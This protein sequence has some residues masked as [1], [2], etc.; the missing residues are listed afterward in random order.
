MI[1]LKRIQLNNFLSH[2]N[3]I[4]NFD[5]NEKAL[6]DGLSGAGK[7]SIFDAIIWNLYGI[8]RADN[9]SLVR[10]GAKLGEVI[11][12]LK[13]DD[14]IVS[15]TRRI[16]ISGKHHL[17][18]T[19]EQIGGIKVPFVTSGLRE[20]QN[21]I[22][23]DLIGASYL[24]FINSVAYVQGNTESFVMQPASK[25]KDLL[26]EIVKTEDY[27]K[28]YENARLTLI[29]LENE[30]NRV[31]WDINALETNLNDLNAVIETR[32]DHIKVISEKTILLN[33]IEPK[34]QVLESKKAELMAVKQGVANLD[35][36]LIEAMRDA[37][38][39][40]T[41]LSKK[42]TKITD[43]KQLQELISTAPEAKKELKESTSKLTKLRK[44][45]SENSK[46]EKERNEFLQKKPVINDYNF[47][48]IDQAERDIKKIKEKPICP[49][50]EKCPYS[51]DHKE[52]IKELRAIVRKIKKTI[53]EE[54]TALTKWTEEFN[55]FPEPKDINFIINEIEI[56]ESNIKII[57]GK[58][59]RIESAQ[60]D[61]SLIDEME[62]ELPSLREK[63]E[64]KEKYIEKIKTEKKL[65]ESTISDVEADRVTSEL[66]QEKQKK[67][68]LKNDIIRATA[69]LENISESETKIRE[70]E[71][72]LKS[73]KN[74]VL[75]IDE[76][77]RKIEL[78]KQ[79]FGSKGIETL[80]IDYLLPKLEDKINEVLSKLSD[81]RIKI[82]T[83]KSSLD[84]ESI[85]E[86]LFITILNEINEEMP[87][88]TYSGGEKLKIS[89]AISEALA[90][91]QKVGFRLFDEMFIGLD[92]NS[93]E[94]FARVLESLQRNFSQVLCISH[95]LQIKDLFDK[96]I[97]IVKTKGISYAK[98]N[99]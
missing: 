95:L 46:I 23:K 86:G 35:N 69:A 36:I 37:N 97:K 72:N 19:T 8:S 24:L 75:V 14:Q 56:L 38:N 13:K 17:I 98:E 7:S 91:L 74:D 42:S 32:G 15:I 41:D 79:A 59:T 90:S 88:E 64:E 51:G 2:E 73:K 82:D 48:N 99:V 25:R 94:S 77:K 3:T 16:T 34:I 65:I 20:I 53:E 44:E 18:A 29:G 26:L 67:D 9:R 11:L 61:L 84:G 30:Q 92:E 87:F 6:I 85:I 52:K 62:A 68:F 33:D 49:S 10:R 71:N 50:G 31:S 80:V 89:V 83:Q 60:K 66:T 4:I 43:K 96:K 93:T 57:E 28:Y 63:L 27:A 12:H 1:L 55:N 54:T 22:E 81:F 40:A 47:Q 39:I 70:I 21:W 5:E 58:I 76:K 45:L 78:I